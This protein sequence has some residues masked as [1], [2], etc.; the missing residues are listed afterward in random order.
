[1]YR[2]EKFERQHLLELKARD[3]VPGLDLVSLGKIYETSPSITG[4][5]GDEIVAC[6]GIVL[7]WK[8]VGEA[9]GFTSDLV[10]RYRIAWFRE[11]E[12]M[13]ESVALACKL[14]RVHCAVITT[15]EKA[16]AFIER[17]EFE[18]EGEFEWYGPNKESY[19]IYRRL[20]VWHS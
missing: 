1:M 18:L 10:E 20:F 2:I 3:G 9:W 15:D 19:Y 17:L 11:V 8:G 6:G 16:I 12:R 4:F 13:I 7:H 5:V 14:H